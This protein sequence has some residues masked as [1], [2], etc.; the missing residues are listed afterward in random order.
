MFEWKKTLK[1]RI[2]Y[3]RPLH[4]WTFKDIL[5][6]TGKMKEEDVEEERKKLADEKY[7]TAWSDYYENA[8]YVYAI[9]DP[10]GL[11]LKGKELAQ[12]LHSWA[13]GMILRIQNIANGVSEPWKLQ[14]R[15]LIT[16]EEWEQGLTE[17]TEDLDGTSETLVN[18]VRKSFELIAGVLDSTLKALKEVTSTIDEE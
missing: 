7:S 9:F 14:G 11:D 6:I 2:V 8:Q 13:K 17:S 3:E 4:R 12:F 16:Q 5:R 1:G 18:E 10:L 15:A